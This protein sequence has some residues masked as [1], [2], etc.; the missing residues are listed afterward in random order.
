MFWLVY[1]PIAFAVAI[2]GTYLFIKF[3]PA[4]RLTD[5]PNQRS[6]H[7]TPIIRGGGIVFVLLWL[8]FS[9]LLFETNYIVLAGIGFA[10]IGFADDLFDLSAK[11][12]LIAQIIIAALLLYS[13]ALP[14][15]LLI[16]Y[17]PCICWSVNL[18]NFMDGTDGIAAI[19]AIFVFALGGILFYWHGASSYATL[20]FILVALVA[21]F[22]VWNYPKARV[23]MGDAGSYFLGSMIAIFAIIG[24]QQYNIPMIS[25]LIMYGVFVFD[26]TV[27]LARRILRRQNFLAAHRLH[28]YQR[29]QNACWR[30]QKILWGVIAINI[31]LFGIAL[32]VAAWPQYQLL[33]LALALVILSMAYYGVERIAPYE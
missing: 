27:T 12:R 2:V 30:H 10:G 22:L 13:L 31:I 28:A 25:W 18:F 24:Y 20:S 14:A 7:S 29:L 11:W 26:G 32:T 3:A 19:E 33:G 21:G 17:I 8:L 4:N 15:W 16:F 5:I 1:L 9:A 6:S 23:F